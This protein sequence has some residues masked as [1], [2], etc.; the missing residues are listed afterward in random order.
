MAD[1]DK[2]VRASL[3]FILAR[4]NDIEVIGE[5]SD[6]L[7]AVELAVQ[8]HPDVVLMDMKMPRKNGLEAIQEIRARLDSPRI[9]VVAMSWGQPM[10]Q[11]AMQNGADG[12]VSKMD[13]FDELVSGIRSVLLG[14]VYLS[15][16]V[17]ESPEG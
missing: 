12:Y 17:V 7:Q 13:I 14:Q 9:L 2:Q 4:A 15:R 8:T 16:H 6:G 3:R 10:V 11:R 1:D 5:A